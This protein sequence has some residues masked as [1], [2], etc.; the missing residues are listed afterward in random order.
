M[1]YLKNPFCTK[2][3][4]EKQWWVMRLGTAYSSSDEAADWLRVSVL[5]CVYLC[6][7]VREKLG[8]RLAYQEG[9][10]TWQ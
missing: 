7:F 4:A 9:E 5:V 3:Y 2:C 1:T 8:C 6:V 10:T